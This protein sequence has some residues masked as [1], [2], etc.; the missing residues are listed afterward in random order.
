MLGYSS[1]FLYY[2]SLYVELLGEYRNSAAST[3]TGHE[4]VTWVRFQE[5]AGLF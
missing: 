5:G 3:E 1:T 2:T 4:L